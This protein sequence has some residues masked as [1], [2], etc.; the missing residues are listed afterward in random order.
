MDDLCNKAI[1]PGF[2]VGKAPRKVVEKKFKSEIKDRVKQGLLLDTLAQ[3]NES[4]DIVPISEPDLDVR[5]VI[6]PDEGPFVYE[7]NIEV[8][9]SSMSR[10]GRS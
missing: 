6:V 1:V 5:A 9:R 10:A 4:E 8:R 7:Y 3:V 2:R